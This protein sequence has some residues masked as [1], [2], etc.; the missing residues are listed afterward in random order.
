MILDVILEEQDTYLTTSNSRNPR[1]M[2]TV[3][4][5]FAKFDVASDPTNL[6]NKW[7]QYISRFDNLLIAM[8]VTDDKRK[9]ALLLHYAGNQVQ[10]IF[11][12]LKITKRLHMTKLFNILEYFQPKRN[13]SYAVFN[14]HKATQKDGE[15]VDQFTAR[16]WE[17]SLHCEL[18]N[19][20]R[21]I[22]SQIELGTNCKKLR[23]YTFRNPDLKLEDLL[24]YGRA[25][26]QSEIHA[27]NIEHGTQ[28][29]A[30]EP[31]VH[32][33]QPG[34]QQRSK[35][36]FFLPRGIT[37]NRLTS[38]ATQNPTPSKSASLVAT[39]FPMLK[40]LPCQNEEL[41]ELWRNWSLCLCLPFKT[42]LKC[43]RGN[44]V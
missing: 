42:I 36:T 14:F 43:K 25:F 18:T 34:R 15:T 31:I 30:G 10:D 40:A 17:L 26:E 12:T 23:R 16:L 35:R 8:N 21:E 44:Q 7:G 6:G 24:L 38:L 28:P 20:G 5:A 4:P 39:I 11:E 22:K 27:K 41:R 19:L 1:R 33:I 2:D 3:L 32:R 37:V 9:K 29:E 13:L